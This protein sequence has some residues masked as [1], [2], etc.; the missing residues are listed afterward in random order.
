VAIRISL[1]L[2]LFDYS[3]CIRR[4]SGIGPESNELLTI[5]DAKFPA[6]VAQ[7]RIP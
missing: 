5:F 6:E 3:K 1:A 2:K 7:F 4:H